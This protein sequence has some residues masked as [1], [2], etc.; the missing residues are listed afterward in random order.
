[1]HNTW[2]T[3][4]YVRHVSR[5]QLCLGVIHVDGAVVIAECFRGQFDLFRHHNVG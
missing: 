3:Y 2:R 4:Q 5:R 1:M